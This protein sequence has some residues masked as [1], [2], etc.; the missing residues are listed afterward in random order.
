MKVFYLARIDTANEDASTRHVFEFCREFARLG[1]QV[2]LLVPD[3]GHRSELPGVKLVYIPVGIRKPALTFLSFYLALFFILPFVFIRHRPEIV[4]S[5]LQ[6]MEWVATLLK[7]GFK[8]KYVVEVNG[9]V[10]VEMK[11]MGYPG[12]WIAFIKAMEGIVFRLADQMVV[13]ST[14]IRDHLCRNYRVPETS[15]LVVSNGANPEYSRPM[16]QLECRRKLRLQ[17]EGRYLVFVGSLKQW[18]GIERLVYL[19]PEMCREIP[20][21][22]MLIVG[23]GEKRPVLDQWIRDHGMSGNVTLAGRVPYEEVPVYINAGDICLAPYFEE[24]L[25]QTGISPLKIFEYMACARPIVTNPVGGLDALFRDYEIGVMIHSMEPRDWIQ[26]IRE[27]LA[28]AGR[29]KVLGHNG[30]QAVQTHFSWEA[31]CTKIST[32]LEQLKSSA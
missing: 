16:D 18:H 20:G 24:R 7:A 3:M 12:W 29:R 21:L 13:P 27:L 6:A 4:Y 19:M 31:I 9:L 5:R 2:T 26:P 11:I 8:F 30:Y 10:P 17:P 14:L 32:T 28:D 22:N 25:N 1:H 23:D 15:V